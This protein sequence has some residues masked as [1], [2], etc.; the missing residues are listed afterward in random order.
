VTGASATEERT[1]RAKAHIIMATSALKEL[2]IQV[3]FA[4][5][6][7]WMD[8][9]M[10]GFTCCMLALYRFVCDP[11]CTA[12]DLVGPGWATT[13]IGGLLLACMVGHGSMMVNCVVRNESVRECM[14][15]G[16][17]SEIQTQTVEQNLALK[18]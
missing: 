3:A 11:I 2:W 1:D 16:L 18:M 17:V 8:G 12:T 4:F 6:K 14:C 10:D 13:A 7:S 5:S 15:M 9:W